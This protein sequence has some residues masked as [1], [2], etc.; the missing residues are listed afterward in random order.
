MNDYLKTQRA[1]RLW[2]K[3]LF[4]ESK[5]QDSVNRDS[6]LRRLKEIAEKIDKD[7]R[8][9]ENKTKHEK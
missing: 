1:P 9:R 8:E 4:Y 2:G 3:P 5:R 6:P 7:K